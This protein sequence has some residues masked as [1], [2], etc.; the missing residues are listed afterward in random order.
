MIAGSTTSA[1]TVGAQKARAIT[2]G[3]KGR[4]GSI[5]ARRIRTEGLKLILDEEWEGSLGEWSDEN[6]GC[7]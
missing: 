2:R 5:M 3:Q 4:S 1:H 7:A 6:A